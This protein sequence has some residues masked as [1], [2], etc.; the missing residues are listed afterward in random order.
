MLGLIKP[1]KGMIFLLVLLALGSNGLTL[2]LPRLISHAIDSFII[3]KLD[4]TSVIGQFLMLAFGIL[5]LTLIQNVIQVYASEK[6]ARDLRTLLTARISRGSFLFVQKENPSKLL[7]Y[8]TS[9]VDSVKMFVA[10]A[11][12]SLISSL[13]IIIGSCVMLLSINWK[14]ALAVMTII[15]VIALTFFLIL[16]KVRKLF[17]QSRQ[18]IDRLNK[19][20]NESIMGAALIRVVHS[21][22]EESTKFNG[23]N[24]EARSLG[25]QILQLFAAMIPIVT[26]VANLGTLIILVLGGRFA[27]QG[28]M[29]IGDFAAFNSYIATFIFPIFI[30]GFMMSII[31][32]A[33]VSYQRIAAVLE[34]EETLDAGRNTQQI[35]GEI[36]VKN[37]SVVYGEKTALKNISFQVKAGTKTAIIGP[38]AA[39]KT[40]LLYLLTHLTLP[41]SGTI[42]YDQRPIIDYESES[43]HRQ[44]GFVFQDSI[45][46]NLTIRENI[47]FSNTVTDASL[48]TAVETAEL[49]DFL[50]QLPEGLN[51]VVS[52]RGTRLSGGQKQRVM[53]ARAL[54]LSPRVLLLD[55]FTARVDAKTEQK[56]LANIARNYPGITLVSVTQ[57]IASVELYDKII[58][59]M[60]GEI[61]AEGT[62]RE[63]MQ[64]CP[65]YV[66]ICN[67]QRSTSHYELPT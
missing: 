47:A 13:V 67:S 30:I 3:E 37:V 48:A 43:L 19:V 45:L 49:Q 42:E 18:V 64:S 33:S 10:Q 8:L 62:H 25:L 5:A 21:R 2:V 57:K 63:L 17:K 24:T 53:L 54:A 34:A 9:D 16:A 26:F 40:Q 50:T 12:A 35:R 31:S 7:T 22:S 59:L 14:L 58:L 36:K 1:Y 52:E 38:T 51:T 27:I 23:A 55:D 39:G 29:S 46:F 6:V 20:I 60:E 65:E 41:T 4:Y 56:I 11:V 28:F 61:L 15:P 32:Q 44:I 66:Q